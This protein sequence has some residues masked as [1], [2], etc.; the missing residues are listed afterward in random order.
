MFLN[1]CKSKE[2]QRRANLFYFF[3]LLQKLASE[4]QLYILIKRFIH[5]PML[6][7]GCVVNLFTLTVLLR[8]PLRSKTTCI[9]MATMAMCDACVL[10]SQFFYISKQLVMWSASLWSCGLIHF[11]FYFTLHCSVLLLIAMATEKYISVR[12]PLKAS[13]WISKKRTRYIILL[14]LL[15]TARKRSLGQGNIFIGVCQEICSWGVS[16]PGGVFSWGVSAPG[17]CLLRGCLVETPRRILLRAVRILLECI[18]LG[19]ILI[20]HTLMFRDVGISKVDNTTISCDY[21]N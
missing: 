20:G 8:K 19:F 5:L 2:L 18:L 15:V 9:Y 10:M 12:F 17:V 6:L 3:L 13:I 21:L 14:L 4:K 7:M 16:A 11:T 1:D